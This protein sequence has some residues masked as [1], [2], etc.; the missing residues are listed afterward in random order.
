LKGVEINLNIL[1]PFFR[2]HRWFSE[3]P[4]LC[5]THHNFGNI[6]L[7]VIFT[8]Y[9]LSYF[10]QGGKDKASPSPLGEGWEGGVKLLH[11]L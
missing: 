4:L 2:G 3:V 10:P 11:K 5:V 6:L 9:P 8:I 1:V 7:S